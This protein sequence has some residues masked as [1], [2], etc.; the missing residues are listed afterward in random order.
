MNVCIRC[1]RSYT[2]NVLNRKQHK[3]QREHV[4]QVFFNYVSVVMIEIIRKEYIDVSKQSMWC[5]GI[6]I[7]TWC[8]IMSINKLLFFYALT[9]RW[10]ITFDFSFARHLITLYFIYKPQHNCM[11]FYL[12]NDWLHVSS[13]PYA[14]RRTNEMQLTYEILFPQ[15]CED[16][17]RSDYKR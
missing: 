4:N 9:W 14:F 17:H 12:N 2:D 16:R 8:F 15:N 6:T 7:C 1:I 10:I 13:V 3:T 5:N 11:Q